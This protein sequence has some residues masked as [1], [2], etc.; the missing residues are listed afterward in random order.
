[1]VECGKVLYALSNVFI[2]SIEYTVYVWIDVRHLLKDYHQRTQTFPLVCFSF[3]V[4]IFLAA[5]LFFKFRFRLNLP[6]LCLQFHL[7]YNNF[8]CVLFLC[9]QEILLFFVIVA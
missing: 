7:Q 6:I 4:F 3:A 9:V 2:R 8:S 1:M 5:Q